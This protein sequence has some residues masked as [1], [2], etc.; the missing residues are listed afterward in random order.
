MTEPATTNEYYGMPVHPV[1]D[2]FPLLTATELDHLANDIQN[3]GLTNPITV[4]SGQILDGR[5]RLL[6]CRKVG[7]EPRYV[8]WR[9]IYHDTENTATVGQWIW[10]VNA[11]R[12]HLT[13][14][15][16]LAVQVA[17]SAWEEQEAAKLKQNEA[18]KRGA[19]GGRGN[20][21]T[22]VTESSQGFPEEQRAPAVRTK[23]AKQLGVSEHKVQ[24]AL[25]VQKADPD[26]LKQVT[27]G[28]VKLSA[29]AKQVKETT[30][31]KK[32]PD[33][34]QQGPAALMLADLRPIMQP[35]LDAVDI[36]LRGMVTDDQRLALVKA[37]FRGKP[38]ME[39]WTKYFEKD[40]TEQRNTFLIALGNWVDELEEL[41][42]AE[43]PL[44]PYQ[45][46]TPE[47][48][49]PEEQAKPNEQAAC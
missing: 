22:V 16:Y 48:V 5:N 19:E 12:R 41:E 29:A 10:S 34:S 2:L 9:D 18:G 4:H 45:K 13:D 38:T 11:E 42:D 21:K 15:Q 6:A 46:K 47:A 32:Q 39:A 17:L 49:T 1:C 25:N 43:Q 44:D 40:K 26:L 33:R 27:N 20:T 30:P 37:R 23:I 36:A 7:V 35:V 8:Q 31:T 14:D 3:H 24:Q 28:T